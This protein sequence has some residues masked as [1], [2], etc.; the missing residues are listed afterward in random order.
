MNNIL[1]IPDNINLDII[2]NDSKLNKLNENS[3]NN[4]SY[5]IAKL[6]FYLYKDEYV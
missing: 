1:I 4:Y 5:N 2:K 6:V 3:L